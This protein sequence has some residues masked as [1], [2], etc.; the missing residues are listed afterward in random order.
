[1]SDLYIIIGHLGL[2]DYDKVELGNLH[3]QVLHSEQKEGLRKVDSALKSL[4]A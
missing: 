2:L 1:M 3:R 4:V